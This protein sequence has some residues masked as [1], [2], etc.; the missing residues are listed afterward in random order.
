MSS[1]KRWARLQTHVLA[2]SPKTR[3]PTWITCNIQNWVLDGKTTK[4]IMQSLNFFSFLDKSVSAFVCVKDFLKKM[5]VT[6]HHLKNIP[7]MHDWLEIILEENKKNLLKSMATSFSKGTWTRG[8]Y[9]QHPDHIL[10]DDTK[11]VLQSF[12]QYYELFDMILFNMEKIR[13]LS[14]DSTSSLPGFSKKMD[15]YTLWTKQ[16]NWSDQ[17]HE[18]VLGQDTISSNNVWMVLGLSLIWR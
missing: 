11:M 1:S 18:V 2:M 8:G 5:E 3:T 16:K 17:R 15:S 10:R 9:D 13:I 6:N 4:Q 7:H 12:Q 14:V